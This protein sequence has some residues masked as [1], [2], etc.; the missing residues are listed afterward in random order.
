MRTSPPSPLSD[1]ERGDNGDC[2]WVAVLPE[3]ELP[4]GRAVRVWADGVRL[5]VG[6]YSDAEGCFAALD[7]C[8]HLDLPLAAFGPVE[9]R[10]SR[11]VCP[12]HWWEFD[13]R[14]GRCEYASLYAND[15]IFFFQLEGKDRPAGEAAGTLRCL[16]AR[17]RDGMVEV[18]L[19]GSD[20]RTAG[21]APESLRQVDL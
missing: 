1:T 21:S 9:V 3:A 14:T 20:E 18:V 12:W 10:D 11:L 2:R 8:P 4:E 16:P 5:I 13:V 6:R 19:P 17:R 15:E 7:L